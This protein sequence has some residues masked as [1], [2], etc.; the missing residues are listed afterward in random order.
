M[1]LFLLLKLFLLGIVLYQIYKRL[2]WYYAARRI[3][4]NYVLLYQKEYKEDDQYV[5]SAT[6]YFPIYHVFIHFWE[7]NLRTFVQCP[8]I[9]DQVISYINKKQVAL[10][11]KLLD[12]IKEEFP[13]K[14]TEDM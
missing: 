13:E 5:V 14:K 9:F 7:K 11:E 1:E 8:E 6:S 3:Y 4:Y 12:L 2:S 10:Y